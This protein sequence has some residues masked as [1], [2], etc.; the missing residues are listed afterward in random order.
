MNLADP[1][2]KTTRA[3]EHLETLKEELSVFYESNPSHFVFE[4]DVKN[5]LHIIRMKIDD[6]PDRITLIAGDIFYNLRAALDQLVWRLAKLTLPYPE[7]TQ[8]PILE[9]RNK[10]LFE[11]RVAGVPAEAAAM[12]EALQPYNGGDIHGHLLW[13]LNKLCNVDK[14]MRIPV[15]GTVGMVRWD[16]PPMLLANGFDNNAEMRIP[17]AMKGKM[18]LNPRV[19]EFCVTFGDMYWGVEVKV[20]GIEAIYE[21][22]TNRVIPRF[23]RFFT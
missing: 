17:L 4:D 15:R 21:F 9:S 2:L 3:K 6:T 7:D 23:A 16:T 14:H 13:Q 22:V 11:R 1:Y 12:I 5:Q 8:F 18:A 19:T 10:S 20:E